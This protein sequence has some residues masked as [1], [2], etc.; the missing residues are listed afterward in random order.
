MKT[1][2][3]EMAG[4]KLH[5]PEARKN[6]ILVKRHEKAFET[7]LHIKESW[8]NKASERQCL[9]II[10]VNFNLTPLLKKTRLH[11]HRNILS[12]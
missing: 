1:D 9:Q 2:K 5:V 10:S 8:K 12:A 3:P 6:D 7:Y 4:R 11:S